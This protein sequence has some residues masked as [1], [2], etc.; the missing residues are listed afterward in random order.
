MKYLFYLSKIYSISI[1]TP[2]VEELERNERD[3][4]FYISDKV[5][6]VFPEKWEKSKILESI[7]ETKKY[8]PDFVLVTGNFVDF[9]IPGIKVQL[10]HGLG[11]E[12]SSHYKI[13]HFFDVYLT[14]GKYVT[15]K[16]KELQKK[17]KY[18]DV[19]ETGWLKIDYIL[20]YPNIDLHKKYEIP[21]GKK[22]ILYAPT[23]SSKMES[24]TELLLFI[25]QI[26]R[27]N[28]FW[29][30]KFHELMP[31]ELIE[32]FKMN[33]SSYKVLRHDEI[34]PY[35]HLSD[36]LISDTSSVVYEFLALDKPAI[37]YKTISRDNKA[38]NITEVSELRKTI[39][40]CLN[41]P[42]FL[43][44]SRDRTMQ[45]VNPYLDG[46]T[47]ERIITILDKLV[48]SDYPKKM[49]PLNLYRKCQIIYHS[50]FKKG[51]LR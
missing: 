43:K 2:L 39:D 19:F 45:E 46:K 47:S 13:R 17:Y 40:D 21:S 33:N 36:L 44:I 35:L 27:E 51:Y 16:Y 29:I 6:K 26:I 10:F 28:E 14:S 38:Y 18:F 1:V 5:K 50:L 20:N 48:L 32:K 15:D 49:K 25:P 7:K 37:T 34:T 42:E 11:V 24:A 8:N 23:F 12:K 41:Y 31:L 3:F 9:R 4:A 30:F 22:I